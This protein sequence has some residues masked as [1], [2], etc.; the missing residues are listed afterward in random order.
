MAQTEPAPDAKAQV[1]HLHV[2]VEEAFHRRLKMLCAIHGVTLKD[3]A[4]LALEEK[5]AR[6]EKEMRDNK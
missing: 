3:Y 2:I 5:V 1:K 6:D 4:R